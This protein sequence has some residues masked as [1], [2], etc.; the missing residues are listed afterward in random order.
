VLPFAQVPKPMALILS[1]ADPLMRP[2]IPRHVLA[3]DHAMNPRASGGSK[4][5]L[6]AAGKEP[7]GICANKP[8]QWHRLIGT[9]DWVI[10]ITP[11]YRQPI[12]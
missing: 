2:S 6:A 7:L 4:A 9:I 3:M 10:P 1:T 5:G 11:A 8:S 12:A